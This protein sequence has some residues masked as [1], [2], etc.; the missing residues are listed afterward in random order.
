MPQQ[1]EAATSLVIQAR[2]LLRQEIT[3]PEIGLILQNLDAAFEGL[4]S[5]KQNQQKG[6]WQEIQ[7]GT[8]D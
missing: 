1:V 3:S 4:R 5:L 8:D 2:N 7:A 6:N